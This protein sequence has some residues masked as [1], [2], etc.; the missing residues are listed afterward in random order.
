MLPRLFQKKELFM[1]K[2]VLKRICL[3]LFTLFVITTL[4]FVLIKLLEPNEITNLTQKEREEAIRDAL[5][6]NEPILVQ[7]FIYLKNIFTKFDFGVSFKISYLASVNSII[8]SKLLPTVLLNVYSLIISIPLGI[9]LGIV[10]ALKKNRWQDHTISTLVMLFVSVPSFV[11]AFILQYFGSKAGLPVTVASVAETGGYF[12]ATMFVSMIL[13]ILALSFGS[14]ASLAR[15]TRAELTESLTSEYMLLARAK[16]LTK[17]QAVMRHA[18]KNAMVPILPTIIAMFVSILSGSLVIEKIF[19]VPG[20]GGLYVTS[21]QELDYNV[22]MAVSIFYTF[23]G[24]VANII[25]DLSY[26]FLDPRIRMGA[27]K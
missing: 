22:F 2:Y 17:G 15:F 3:M 19:A 6:Y 14:I 11:Y 7:Y 24:L 16:G 8:E 23:I 26:G 5:G 13:P 21:I 9:L 27:K 20:I 25:V 10:A 4:C 12:T 18:L 1:K